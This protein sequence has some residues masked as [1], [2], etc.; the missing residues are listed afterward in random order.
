MLSPRQCGEPY[1]TTLFKDL[2]IKVL[3]MNIVCNKANIGTRFAVS[4]H[5]SESARA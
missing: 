2:H 1:T 3:N 4:G 5:L